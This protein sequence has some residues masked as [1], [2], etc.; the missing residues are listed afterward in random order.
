[1]T[2]PRL[3]VGEEWA[4]AFAGVGNNR[5]GGVRVGVGEAG[6]DEALGVLLVHGC[7][8]LDDFKVLVFQGSDF[9]GDTHYD[10]VVGDAGILENY[11]ACADD[12]VVPNFG[13]FKEYG[14]DAYHDVVADA[15][16][17]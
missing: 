1:M 10:G 9:A 11:G 17:V 8:A 4:P 13:I 12:A 14:V 6:L 2:M 5:E 7:A 15:V 16:T 3:D